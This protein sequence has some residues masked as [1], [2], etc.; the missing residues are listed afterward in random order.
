[1]MGVHGMREIIKKGKTV[2][3]AVEL[4]LAELGADR[5]EVLIDVLT[6]GN[7]GLFG[8]LGGKEAEVRVT[9]EEKSAEDIAADF[10]KGVLE[11]MNL[12]ASLEIKA[13][14]DTM[15]ID[16]T[17]EDMGIIIGRR[18]ETL[19][20]LQYLTNLVVNRNAEGFRRITID[21]ENYKKKREET[22]IRLAEKTAEK[23]CKYKRNLTLDPM[24]PYERRIV[25]SALQSN[26]FVN[27]YSTGEEP[28]RRVVVVFNRSGEK[29]V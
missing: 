28:N 25:H 5:S 10:L 21:T 3:E 24:N 19:T 7:K 6:E 29:D 15:E 13:D 22:L 14:D 18:G 17:G 8:I 9:L 4:A 23:V 2:D 16:I 20:A 26:T 27:T 1:M 11:K 12:H